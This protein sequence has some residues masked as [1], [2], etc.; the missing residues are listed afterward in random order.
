VLLPLLTRED[1]H[2]RSGEDREFANDF[3]VV[4]ADKGA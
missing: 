3:F 1:Q 4:V 2:Q